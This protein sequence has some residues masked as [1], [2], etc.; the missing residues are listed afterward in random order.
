[1]F[2]YIRALFA[3]FCVSVSACS[4]DSRDVSTAAPGLRPPGDVEGDGSGRLVVQPQSVPFGP[5][6]VGFAA[7]AHIFVENAGTTALP[8]PA[9][10][11]GGEGSLSFAITQND[12][13]AELAGGAHCAVALA[14]RPIDLSAR[15]ASIALVAGASSVEVAL[16]GSGLEA[17]DLILQ[18][19][20]GSA[21]T[22]GDVVMQGE[23]VAT[24]RLS[25]PTEVDSGAIQLISNNAAFSVLPAVTGE[26]ASGL[27]RLAGGQSCD[28]RVRFS[29]VGRGVIAGT[30]TAQS[31]ASGSVSLNV[32]GKALALARLLVS[33]A[34]L[35]FGDV[36][37]G[38]GSVLD[39]AISNGGDEPMPAVEGVIAGQAASDF[40]V[41]ANACSAAL[42]AGASCGI[43]V[44]FVPSAP[45]VQS[46]ALDL[47]AGSAGSARVELR[48]TGLTAGELIVTAADESSNDFGSVVIG[49]AAEQVFRVTNPADVASGPLELAVNSEEFS[50][51]VP[52][53][54]DCASGLTD[55]APG[56]SCEVRV[57]F[58]PTER[59]RRNATLSVS[60]NVG[61]TGLN[62]S[63]TGLAPAALEA[64]GPVDFGGVPRNNTASR[65]L[66][67]TNSG[68]EL[69]GD[70][71]ASL[72]GPNAAEFTVQQN[73][74]V[75]GLANQG[76]CSIAIAFVPSVSG[77]RIATLTLVG[78]PGGTRNV[79]LSGLGL[80]PGSL[81]LAPAAG[82]STIFGDSLVVGG[83]G[84]QRQ[85]F[86]LSNPGQIASG[87]INISPIYG[88]FRVLAASGTDCV[89]NVTNLQAGATCTIRVE[90]TP[91]GRGINAA[92]L[93]VG[94]VAAG[95]TSLELSGSGLGPA[96][97]SVLTPQINFNNPVVVG[98]TATAPLT[99]RNQGD[100]VTGALS[101]SIV[102]LAAGFSV[103]PGTCT[104]PLA[105]GASCSF[106]VRFTPGGSG[107]SSSTVRVGST[108][109]GTFDVPLSGSA[110]LPGALALSAVTSTD[111]GGVGTNSNRTLSF[112]LRNTGDLTAGVLL[113]ITLGTG[114][115]R[116]AAMNGECALNSTVLG[117][118]QSCTFRVVFQPATTGNF[119]VTM[120]ATSQLGGSSSLSIRGAGQSPPVFSAVRTLAFVGSVFPGNQGS[121]NQFWTITNTGGS[122]A[123][124]PMVTNSNPTEF[125]GPF[126]NTCTG[127][128]PAG[129]QCSMFFQLAPTAAGT[130]MATITLRSGNVSISATITGVGM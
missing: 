74:C 116:A 84:S 85:T 89:S 43:S 118:G 93:T 10:T 72:S 38:G 69:L 15:A 117:G 34:E 83:S 14:F 94:S 112:T 120:V 3:L 58:A 101:A 108:P 50:I 71:A 2:R 61:S 26:C 107:L 20:P 22:F 109:G 77:S 64:Q 121:E 73:G 60:S 17:G 104:G 6:A 5:I 40:R 33:R 75:L 129:G 123:E 23:Q 130:R 115:T 48:G 13:T 95:S 52:S 100:E 30:I 47:N 113:G 62:L 110:Q 70:V 68:D 11:L 51:V 57:S 103:G 91:L 78:T 24:L 35:D 25:N 21:V 1:M 111:F 7:A 98:Q 28:V 4:I 56:A 114:F 65:S 67:V 39:L 44:S 42:A 119:A 122:T 8:V 124:N 59:Q 87:V 32:S 92:T 76:T 45:G 54:S 82:G 53:G 9:V 63:G 66:T 81:V 29:P 99:V 96:E 36:V 106:D 55:L 19:A 128:L 126:T 127:S 31:E 80:E 86:V 46:A 18:A 37:E 97:L 90:F 125:R 16:S 12:C 88:G 105:G 79:A 27:T 41:S 102:G 49:D